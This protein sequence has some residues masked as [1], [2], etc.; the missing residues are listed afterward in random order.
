MNTL[1][2]N[3]YYYAKACTLWNK[4]LCSSS[5][6]MAF[7]ALHLDSSL[8]GKGCPVMHLKDTQH[9]HKWKSHGEVGR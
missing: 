4:S 7:V 8:L 2:F 6:N 1:I 5:E 3:I 9:A